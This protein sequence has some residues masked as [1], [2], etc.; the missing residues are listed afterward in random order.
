M[1]A[2]KSEF[3]LPLPSEFLQ[4]RPG[5]ASSAPPNLSVTSRESQLKEVPVAE[6]PIDEGLARI[7]G[8]LQEDLTRATERIHSLALPSQRGIQAP[9]GYAVEDGGRLLGPTTVLLS[10][11]LLEEQAGPA[12]HSRIVD[13]AAAVGILH[14]A[15]LCHDD[16]IDGARTRRGRP[17]ANAR[18]GDT[19][20]LL[21]GDH[22]LARAMRA[23]AL[24]GESRV[25][26]LADALADVSTGKMLE[27]GQLF[28]PLRTEAD[29]LA[30]IPGKTPRVL[31][32][33]AAMSAL[34][35]DAGEEAQG[36]LDGFGYHLGMAFQIW[37]DILELLDGETG[38][39]GETAGKPWNGVYTLPVIYAVKELPDRLLPILGE[40]APSA[41]RYREALSVLRES[42]AIC[43]AAELA[44]R[45]LADAL[46]ALESHP[47]FAER[48]PAV[49]RH[50]G[51]L[52][53]EL[54]ARHPELGAPRGT[55]PPDPGALPA[56][57]T[58]AAV[59]HDWLNDYVSMPSPHIGRSGAVCP[60]V[61]PSLRAG[62][63]E[64]HIRPVGPDPTVAR[65]EET[66]L[67]GLDEYHR[68]DWK[69]SN[70]SLRSLL[71][72]IPDL[73][74]SAC[75]LL[76]D[77]HRAAKPTAVRRGMMIGQFHPLCEEP[78]I[79]NPEFPVSRSP[80]PLVAIRPMALHDVLFLNDSKEWFAEYH[81]RFGD[82]YM[83]GRSTVDPLFAEL[84]QRAVAEHGT[85]A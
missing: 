1:R 82:H 14:A 51:D 2:V 55:E 70:P 78:A 48:V 73:D 3:T 18:Y 53:D 12:A 41:D 63:L 27:A 22:L 64:T 24:L 42:G 85:G 33:A 81:R 38:E 58:A 13:A 84:F 35:F 67:W 30:A 10:A 31:R 5:A 74:T 71:V 47:P 21:T 76:D 23:A 45:H 37:Y 40:E 72:A 60:F 39:T 28:D 15:A 65:L 20:A 59:I 62:S 75:H 36:A 19:L 26:V 68:I 32:A 79:R 52:A 43:R 49:A 25:A 77:A 8:R 11:Y 54:T 50:V 17:T 83:S 34:E 16:L 6:S 80:V 56:D 29:Y 66:I 44:R 46:H 9:I 7:H 57:D 4:T 61:R 69:G